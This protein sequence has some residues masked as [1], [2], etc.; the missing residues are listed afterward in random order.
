MTKISKRDHK[1]LLRSKRLA[2]LMEIDKLEKLRCEYCSV[3]SGY[4]LD[5]K[6]KCDCHASAE[7]GKLGK[8]LLKLVRKRGEAQISEDLPI[9]D[10]K[11]VTF[12]N[13]TPDIYKSLKYQGLTD[14][15]IY[16]N[17]KIGDRRLRAWKEEN[18]IKPGNRKTDYQGI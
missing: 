10:V 12:E 18:G 5:N 16:K 15:V 9:V 1:K 11:T 6:S 14:K 13:M 8:E 7:I 3:D 17:L 2:I 4:T